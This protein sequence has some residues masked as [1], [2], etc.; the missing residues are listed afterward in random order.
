MQ[1]KSWSFF[2]V[3][4]LSCCL[5]NSFSIAQ[6]V[7]IQPRFPKVT[8]SLTITYDATQGNAGLKD[9]TD[10]F[11][12]SGVITSGPNGATW[13]SVP[14]VWGSSNSKWKLTNLGG[15]KFQIKYK[16]VNFY[17]I[18]SNA[19]VYRLV[20][21]FRNRTG[22]ITGKTETGGDIFMPIYQPGQSAIKFFEPFLKSLEVE[23]NTVV[24]YVGAAN[25]NSNLKIFL[26]DTLL[27]QVQNDTIVTGNVPTNISG[28][29]KLKLRSGNNTV[30][31]DSF[32]VL[33]RP[34]IQI[35]ALPIGVEDG[36]NQ[37]SS[38]SA[39]FC[40]RAPGKNIV[41][42]KGEFNN[43]LLNEASQMKKTPDGK[44]WWILI[45]NLDPLKS[46]SYQYFV[47]GK[48]SIADP[49][50][51]IILDPF[52]DQNISQINYPNLKPYP[53]GK[54]TGNVSVCTTGPSGFV[55]T[56]PNFQRPAKKDL[57]IYELLIRDFGVPKTFGFLSD[58]LTYLAKLG[59]NCIQ[60]MP[61]MEFE[62][63]LSWG[64]NTSHHFALDKYYG[65]ETAFK[66]F[67]DK[68]HSLGIA[69]VLDIALNHCYGQSPLVQ[70]YWD[71]VLNRPAAN[72][73]WINPM[74]K[75][76]FN[77]GYDMNHES[78]DTRYYV[79]RVMKH[80]LTE[81]KVDGFRWDLS[82]G[83]TQKNT[84]TTPNCDSG[85]EIYNWGL[86]DPTRIAIWKNLYDDMQSY[87]PGSYSILEHFAENSE[88]TELSNYGHMFWGNLN[89]NY[90][91]A[92]R[93]YP[94]NSDL[95]Y[96]Y[97]KSRGW[98][99]PNLITYMESH[100]EERLMYRNIN[101]G[102][103][104][105][106][107]LGYNVRDTA[108]G[109]DRVKLASCFF[110]TI[111]GPKMLWQFGELGYGFSI[112]YCINNGSINT[113]CRTG[114]KPIQWFYFNQTNRRS[115]HKVTQSLIALKRLEPVF[116]TENVVLT[117]GTSAIVKR[118]VLSHSS[119]NVVVLGNFSVVS[120][121][122]VPNFTS[123]GVWYEFFTG[124]S[125]VVSSVSAPIAFQPGEYRIYSN[126]KWKSPDTYIDLL[127]SSVPAKTNGSMKVFPNPASD[128]CEFQLPNFLDEKVSISIFDISGNTIYQTE[129]Q[130]FAGSILLDLHSFNFKNGLHACKI[131]SKNKV[132][133]SSLILNK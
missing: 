109:L 19:T 111:P 52:N 82:K 133:F 129:H 88:E 36:F 7:K 66:Q 78:A 42:L 47:D 114:L 12:H 29:K 49:Y 107:A 68:A 117:V 38:T 94:G 15:N 73:P 86:Y 17:N 108:T 72:N 3:F 105:Q 106:A 6:I 132:Y 91:E 33:V 83:F 113:N 125:I 44:F 97:Y 5:V 119:R 85:N 84:C 100:D 71:P 74:P 118:I 77:V 121:Q 110:Y 76:S 37:L 25:F 23:A 115:L 92:A 104:T 96:G 4:L 131:I 67:I 57:V 69:V 31:V 30:L 124:D 46:Y 90:I 9:C 26:N 58:S 45:Q 80:W 35:E 24:S 89:Y 70:L 123:T 8:D 120:R 102:N 62:G 34:P 43:W 54:T 128:Y 39:V 61:V 2:L 50:S 14:T 13:S 53:I 18:S 40:L 64:Y 65:S 101:E 21:V 60:L 75:H 99:N 127:L 22:S 10:I 55:W 27:N 16:P 116:S 51:K 95:S 20:F 56:N 41:Y 93:G 48:I 126:K 130:T 28:L 63:N 11:I 103:N 87:S 112:N 1:L 59:I 79:D 122:A 81:Y 98:S 32:S